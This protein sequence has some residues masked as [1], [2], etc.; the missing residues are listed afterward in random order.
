M[1]A[2]VL[3]H[4]GAPGLTPGDAVSHEHSRRSH[5]GCPDCEAAARGEVGPS[6]DPLTPDGWVYASEDRQYARYY[7]SLY[8]RGWLYRVRLTDPE[9]SIEDVAMF[10]SWRARSATVVSVLERAVLLTMRERR[11]LFVRSGGTEREWQAMLGAA[12]GERA[13]G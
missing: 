3:F 1:T 12:L 5:D 2:L 6:A 4:G 9:P 10:P 13:A 7:A 11:R 8:G